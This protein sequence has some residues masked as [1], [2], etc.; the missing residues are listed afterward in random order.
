MWH[1][2]NIACYEDG[3]KVEKIRSERDYIL[4]EEDHTGFIDSSPIIWERDNMNIKITDQITDEVSWCEIKTLDDSTLIL[5]YI[6]ELDAY[7]WERYETYK[8]IK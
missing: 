2:T 7:T 1:F 8:R 5:Y 3:V 4:F 6:I